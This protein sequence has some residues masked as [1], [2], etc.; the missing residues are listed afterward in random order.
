[1]ALLL[2]RSLSRARFTSRYPLLLA[3]VLSACDGGVT[4]DPDAG[5]LAP[6]GSSLAPGDASAADAAVGRDAT[7]PIDAAP[8]TDAAATAVDASVDAGM[9]AGDGAVDDAGSL[10][11]PLRFESASALRSDANVIVEK[12]EYLSEG[13]RIV[14]QVCRPNPAGPQGAGP[15]PV[16]I[17]NHGGFS[18]ITDWNGGNCV[19]NAQKGWV[20]A[21]SSYRGEDG[22]EGAVE[23][24]LGEVTD[25]LRLTAIVLAQ[26]Y[27]DPTHVYMSGISHGGCITTRAVQ[28]GAPVQLAIDMFGP[29]DWALAYDG[30]VAGIAA[31]SPVRGNLQLLK[32]V[33]DEAIGGG[34]AQFP[35]EYARRSPRSFGPDLDRARLPFLRLQGGADAYVPSAQGCALAAAST[36]FL[37]YHVATSGAVLATAPSECASFGLTWEAGPR[38]TTW[39]AE[40][41][42]ML[43]DDVGHSF[44]G[45]GAGSLFTDLIGYLLARFPK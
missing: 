18:G 39:P 31:S 27:A 23:V 20:V 45:S 37:N 40:R 35:A 21:E 17:A 32:D 44:E 41:Y 12:V 38:P 16:A 15:F 3:S 7:A 4:R 29:T 24:C 11:G 28:R 1:M 34:P 22:S 14:G 5:A 36:G 43:Y 26:P 9:D 2:T 8:A 6:D 30:W 33:L 25:V 19:D 13:L 42:L 10:A